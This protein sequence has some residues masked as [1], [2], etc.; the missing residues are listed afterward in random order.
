MDESQEQT[1]QPQTTTDRRLIDLARALADGEDEL[2]AIRTRRKEVAK[3]FGEAERAC[4]GKLAD[5]R[6]DF[7]SACTQA[8]LPGMPA[9]EALYRPIVWRTES[10]EVPEG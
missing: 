7:R 10:V 5:L 8:E 1:P 6:G 3:R 2:A 4:L 9:V